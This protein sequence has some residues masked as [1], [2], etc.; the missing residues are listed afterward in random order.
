MWN[1]KKVPICLQI[2]IFSGRSVNG[3]EN[4]V[5][6]YGNRTIV[7]TEIGFVNRKFIAITRLIKPAV[8]QNMNRI[9]FIL[10]FVKGIANNIAAFDRNFK[11]TEIP[12][13]GNGYMFF[14]NKKRLEA[15]L[16]KY[17]I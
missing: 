3:V 16:Q 10:V 14:L 7:E 9:H 1:A 8:L 12:A 6:R 2:S 5:G 4:R 17:G 13:N 15:A 11:F